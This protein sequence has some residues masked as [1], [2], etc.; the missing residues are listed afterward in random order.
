[1]PLL[2]NTTTGYGLVSIILHWL[3]FLM[4]C[5]VFAVGFYMVELTYYDPLYHELPE[6]HK[7]WGFA[8]ALTTLIRLL[9]KAV[10]PRPELLSGRRWEVLMARSMHGFL[11]CLLLLLFLTGYLMTV[12]EGKA[13]TAFEF[14]LMPA[15]LELN[16]Q[17]VDLAGVLHWG[18][19]WLLMAMM[20]L[21]GAAACK[22]HFIDRDQ[23]LIRMLS[24]KNTDQN[25]S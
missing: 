13:L 12:A 14:T 1:M 25:R 3:S 15:L 22:H 17:Q 16:P 21:H 6:W 20:G 11:Y 9:W 23:T 10:N 19:A 4:V 18:I 7:L 24:I 5:G 2:G 8:L